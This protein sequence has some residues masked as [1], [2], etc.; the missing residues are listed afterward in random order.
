MASKVKSGVRKVV[1]IPLKAFIFIMVFS[2]VIGFIWLSSFGI[3]TVD[4]FDNGITNFGK[5]LSKTP[6]N[7]VPWL[8][9]FLQIVLG[10]D[11]PLTVEQLI[12]HLAV[13]FIIFFA[14]GEIV[15][16]VTVFSGFTSWLISLSLALV[17]GVTGVV[18][19]VVGLMALTAGLSLIG[20]M[21]IILTAVFAAVTLHVGLGQAIRRW[22]LERQIE[23]DNLK[24]M[25]KSGTIKNTLRTINDVGEGFVGGAGI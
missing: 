20:I 7:L 22:R 2:I 12:V 4:G 25:K 17:A 23:K 1:G 9:G 10:I 11:P 19:Y 3:K 14:L 15:A 21:I 5:G 8:D 24:M 18:P 6:I 13:F 16:L